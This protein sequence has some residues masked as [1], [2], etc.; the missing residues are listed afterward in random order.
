M[1]FAILALIMSAVVHEYSH[2]WMAFKLGDTTA[3][4]MGRLTLNPIKHLDLFGSIIL[5]TLLVLSSSTFFIAWA[6]P[7]PFNPYRLSDLKFGP[8]KVALAG[9]FSNFVMAVIF[10]LLARGLA[11]PAHTKVELTVNFLSGQHDLLL[12]MMG[13]NF[14]YTIFVMFVIVVFVNLALMIF[15]LVPIPPLDGSKIIYTFLPNNLKEWFYRVE[16]YSLFILILLIVLGF[17]SFIIP[18]ILGIFG[19]IVGI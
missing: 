13:G 17:F 9:P 19:L 3:K 15:N 6:K 1:I 18:L 16:R 14:V 5:P 11:I 4:D 12:S 10:G 8:L 7:V 2:G